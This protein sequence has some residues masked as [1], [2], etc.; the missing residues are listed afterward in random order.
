MQAARPV[1][2]M[3]GRCPAAMECPGA[4]PLDS[5]PAV[6]AE[7]HLCVRPL[8]CAPCLL[9]HLPLLPPPTSPCLVHP[10]PGPSCAE[11]D[12]RLWRLSSKLHT[13][14]PLSTL[15]ASLAPCS[16]SCS[17]RSHSPHKSHSGPACWQPSPLECAGHGAGVAASAGE[18]PGQREEGR[19]EHAQRLA[20]NNH[21][22]TVRLYGWVQNQRGHRQFWG[23]GPMCLLSRVHFAPT[24]YGCPLA[25]FSV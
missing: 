24:A 7:R 14:L 12:L 4:Q 23:C 18:A 16:I 9:L 19:E 17:M 11:C 25:A 15:P 13:L 8:R 2:R 6:C 1:P 21:E 20:A 3:R 10:K 22:P 5:G